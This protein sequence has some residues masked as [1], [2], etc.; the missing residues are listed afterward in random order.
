MRWR[1]GD[2]NP[3]QMPTPAQ[4]NVEIGDLMYLD[5][6]SAFPASSLEDQGTL[7]GNQ[8]LF[9]DVF[10]GVA[11]QS[12]PIGHAGPI[13]IATSGVFEFDCVPGPRELGALIGTTENAAGNQLESQ[14]VAEVS[15]A[16]AAIGRCAKRSPTVTTRILVDVVSTV[17]KGGP[18]T[19]A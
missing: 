19:P 8:Q 1:Y 12:S 10:L 5:D 17:M 2:T 6:A 7:L 18:Q 13:R 9:Q 4:V 11:M 16:T 14:R 15:T 3:V